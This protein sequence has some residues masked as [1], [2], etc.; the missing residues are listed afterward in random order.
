MATVFTC[1]LEY[2]DR[3]TL[4][5]LRLLGN[6]VLALFSPSRQS[7]RSAHF[8]QTFPCNPLLRVCGYS[9]ATARMLTF[10]ICDSR[11]R[12]T[13]AT[14]FVQKGYLCEIGRRR[15]A[16]SLSICMSL[17]LPYPGYFSFVA[18]KYSRC[19]GVVHLARALGKKVHS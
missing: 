17:G 13:C 9:C 6:G 15:G 5:Q 8:P 14:V 3:G 18:T 7:M 12:P 19:L 11:E 2:F 4:I 1:E 16:R 10:V